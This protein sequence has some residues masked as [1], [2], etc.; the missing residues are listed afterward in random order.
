MFIFFPG[1]PGWAA[2]QGRVW[3]VSTAQILCETGQ[4]CITTQN[5]LPTN[6][7]AKWHH[8]LHSTDS[9]KLLGQSQEWRRGRSQIITYVTFCFSHWTLLQWL[10]I[11]LLFC[12]TN[13]FFWS[14]SVSLSARKG[15]ETDVTPQRF[16]VTVFFPVSLWR[17]VRLSCEFVWRRSLQRW[18][19]PPWHMLF[20]FLF[21]ALTPFFDVW[22]TCLFQSSVADR[23][24]GWSNSM[25]ICCHWLF[26][27]A[28]PSVAL[29]GQTGRT[30][31][32]HRLCQVCEMQTSTFYCRPLGT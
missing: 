18:K 11:V 14:S 5:L 6:C 2:L 7:G 20:V 3:E 1:A 10:L 22:A 30:P 12:N 13:R 24:S 19:F 16:L 26:S 29:R 21:L 4:W 17:Q 32:T 9:G 8:H 15:N 23:F 27:T 31:I 28:C 25:E